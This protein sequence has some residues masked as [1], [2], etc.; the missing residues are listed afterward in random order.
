MLKHFINNQW[1]ESTGAYFQ[2]TNPSTGKHLLTVPIGDGG[3]VHD[4]VNAART[5][6]HTW[7]LKSRVARAEYLKTVSSLI[8]KYKDDIAND[9]S[10][11]TGKSLNESL[12]EV[13]E[14]IHMVDYSFGRGREN[15]GEVLPSELDERD[16]QIIRKPKGVLSIC[17]PWNFPFAIAYWNSAPALIEGNAVILKPSE[18]APLSARW[19]AHIYEEAGLPAGVFNLVYGDGNTGENLVRENVQHVSFTGSA[20]TGKKIRQICAETWGKSCSLEMGSKS[21]VAVMEDADIDMA[22]DASIA[23]AFKLSG[24]RCVSAGR[25]LISR[26]RYDEFCS[27]FVDR[28]AAL[29]IGNP[30]NGNF[31][32]GPLINQRQ[33]KKVSEFNSKSPGKVLLKGKQLD[34]DGYFMTPHVYQTE[35]LDDPCL[36]QEVFG[37]HVALVPFDNTEECVRI[38]NDT[39]YGLA[40]GVITDDFRIMR[41][42]KTHCDTGMIYFNLGSV[43]AESFLPFTGVKASGYGGGSAAASHDTF[44]DQ[45]AVSVNYGY[46][47]IMPQG[48][49]I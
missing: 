6:F 33:M 4:A 28:A 31:D 15:Y 35:W 41:Y 5:A 8:T 14:A 17:C 32:F 22:V 1:L 42:M 13:V 26:C 46:K 34:T 9:I 39:Q 10:L 25:I 29:K 7:K 36:K 48:L 11:E 19:I 18:E 2:K 27:R 12:A 24:Q 40:F 45:M 44:T 30:F 20:A 21:A 23:S 37:P 47:I 49:K 43:G 16:C 38:F 3:N